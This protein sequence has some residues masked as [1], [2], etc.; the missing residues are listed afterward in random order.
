MGEI[1]ETSIT[2]MAGAGVSGEKEIPVDPAGRPLTLRETRILFLAGCGGKLKV[3]LKYGNMPIVPETGWATGD[4]S[5]FISGKTWEFDAGTPLRVEFV[6]EDTANP[7]SA[8]VT[9]T[10]EVG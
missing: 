1:K 6:N 9:I 10:Y 7:H 4:D 8:V 5:K 3:R 2:V